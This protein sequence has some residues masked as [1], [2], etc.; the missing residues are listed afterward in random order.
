[1]DWVKKIDELKVVLDLE[2]DAQAGVILG[3][4][5]SMMSMVRTGRAELPAV[6]KYV[7]LDKLGYAK[8]RAG[9]LKVLGLTLPKDFAAKIVDLDNTSYKKKLVEQPELRKVIQKLLK[10]GVAAEEI[11]MIVDD[12]LAKSSQNKDLL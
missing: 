10:K 3:L 12:E 7:L 6:A 8:T 2:T 5:R 11:E 4:S 9:V 1:M